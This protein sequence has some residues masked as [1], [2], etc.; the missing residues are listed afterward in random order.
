MKVLIIAAFPGLAFMPRGYQLAKHLTELGDQVH[1]ITWDP[2]TTNIRDIKKSLSS[3]LRYK[4]YIKDGVI[5]HKTRRLPFPF[6][7][8]NGCMFKKFVSQISKREGLEAIISASFFNEFEPPFDLPLVYDLWDHF[9]SFSNMYDG[10]V[11]RF[12]F[13]YIVNMK[14]CIRAQIKHAAAV[15]AVS[16]I[17]VDYAK[18]I[19][20]NIPAY[21]ILNGVGSLFLEASLEKSKNKLGKD[22]MVYVANFTEWANLPKLIQA[23]RLV[24]TNYPDIKLVLVGDGPAVPGAKELVRNLGL[25]EHVHFVGHV[26]HE[27]VVSIISSC[28]IA[29]CPFQK[30][31]H[32]D[33]AFPIKIMEYT[34]LGKKIVSSNLEEVKL[35]DFPNIVVYDESKGVEELANAIVK[36]FTADIDPSE[37]RKYAYKYTWT[38]I[39]K[40]FQSVLR[41]VVE[42]RKG[43]AS[44]GE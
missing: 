6:P 39:A 8:I 13:R 20:P 26:E 35:L 1:Y 17:L 11:R 31:L 32:T 19:N 28:E 24:K 9:E 14:K 3:S 29:L 43:Q 7:P 34:A 25:S 12:G 27:E 4:A 37:T 40:Q 5:V 33:A 44:K 36:A 42:Q 41:E 23:T 18:K 22:S 30:N 10:R 38:V 2:Y 15:T 21:K 16:D